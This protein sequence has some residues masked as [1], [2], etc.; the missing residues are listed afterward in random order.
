MAKA[1]L[2]GKSPY[3]SILRHS[4]Q[5]VDYIVSTLHFRP[6]ALKDVLWAKLAPSRLSMKSSLVMHKYLTLPDKPPN[7]T[8]YPVLH[9]VM[10][11]TIY[12]N[13]AIRQ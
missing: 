8:W 3:D 4:V 6:R 7:L 13:A 12:Y 9:L 1:C 2:H 11:D 10:A 5:I